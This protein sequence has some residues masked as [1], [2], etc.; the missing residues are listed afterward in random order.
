[1][2]ELRD[3]L[4]NHCILSDDP[5]QYSIYNMATK[6]RADGT[7]EICLFKHVAIIKEGGSFGERALL[8]NTFRAASI[9]CKTPCMFVTLN[10]HDYNRILGETHKK[11]IRE[12]VEFFKN[13]RIFK[14]L[15]SYIIEKIAYYMDEKT[16]THGQY[17]YQENVSNNDG[18]YFIK[19]GQFEILRKVERKEADH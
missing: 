17:V 3:L 6:D 10:R 14:G 5:V 16:Y 19:E 7:Q 1:M 15:T 11:K 4:L 9:V 13:F 8:N 2:S 12:Q 18:L